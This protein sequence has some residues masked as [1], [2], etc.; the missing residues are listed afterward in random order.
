MLVYYGWN[1]VFFNSYSEVLTPISQNVT[2]VGET[3]A[4]FMVGLS[5]MSPSLVE[6]IT[7]QNSI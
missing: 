6:N 2:F 5:P 4:Q 1:C 3:G 7:N